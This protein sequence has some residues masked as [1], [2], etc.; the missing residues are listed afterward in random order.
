MYSIVGAA[1][2]DTECM[3]WSFIEAHPAHISLPAYTKLEA[4][5]VLMWAWAGMLLVP[6]LTRRNDVLIYL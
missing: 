6:L 4:M 2:L 3:Y 5:D 1:N